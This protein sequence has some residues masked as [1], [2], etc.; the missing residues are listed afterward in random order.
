MVILLYKWLLLASNDAGQWSARLLQRLLKPATR[1]YVSVTE[2]E[3]NATGKNLGNILQDH[4]LMI[5]KKHWRSNFKAK[6]D[7][8]APADKSEA[9][10]MVKEYIKSH[11]QLKVDNKAVTL[12]LLGLKKRMMRCGVILK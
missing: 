2:M 1:V 9:D 4:L 6:V 7:L 3:Y 12:N 10:R 11:L 8:T 5:L